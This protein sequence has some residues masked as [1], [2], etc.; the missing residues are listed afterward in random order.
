MSRLKVG[1]V[2]VGIGRAHLKGYQNLTEQVEIVAACDV[3]EV[4]LNQVADEFN[5]FPIRAAQHHQ[6]ALHKKQQNS[7]C[8]AGVGK[9][10]HHLLFQ[11]RVIGNRAQNRQK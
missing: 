10:H 11:V 9:K 7:G 8:R 6:I 4:R 1:V 2:G 3:N 5:D